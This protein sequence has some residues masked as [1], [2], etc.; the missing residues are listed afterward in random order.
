MRPCCVDLDHVQK[1]C[2]A[3]FLRIVVECLNL[4]SVI[5][6]HGTEFFCECPP[7]PNKLM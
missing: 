5:Q 4:F 2:R 3:Y 1:F 6:A 7:V